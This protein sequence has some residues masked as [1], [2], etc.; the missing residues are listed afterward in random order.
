MGMLLIH[1]IADSFRETKIL[2]TVRVRV[3]VYSSSCAVGLPERFKTG[4]IV[5][6]TGA[7]ERA[8]KL[9]G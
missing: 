8:S 5:Q 4:F 2:V 1:L 3:N 6:P 7:A 9:K